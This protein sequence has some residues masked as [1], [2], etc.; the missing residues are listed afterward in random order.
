MRT[1]IEVEFLEDTEVFWVDLIPKATNDITKIVK[2][3]VAEFDVI[4]ENDESL[5]VIDDF[6]IIVGL[7]LNKI[8][9]TT[10]WKP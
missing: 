9:I 4:D 2:G 8:K 5:I 7:P 6:G 3:A 1:H 10:E